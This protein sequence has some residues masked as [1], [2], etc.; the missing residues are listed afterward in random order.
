MVDS[1]WD[2]PDHRSISI[3]ANNLFEVRK[4]DAT[5]FVCGNSGSANHL[6]NDSLYGINPD[7]KRI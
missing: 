5:V 2:E 6:A 7:A 1:V 3:L 4:N